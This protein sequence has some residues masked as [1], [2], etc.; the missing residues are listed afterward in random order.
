[1]YLENIEINF[2]QLLRKKLDS[3]S[4][5]AQVRQFADEYCFLIHLFKVK[6]IK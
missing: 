1:V 3:P 5:Q 2:G 6:N 4:K